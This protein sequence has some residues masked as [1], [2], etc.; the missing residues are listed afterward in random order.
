MHG[1]TTRRPGSNPARA[2]SDADPLLH[3]QR[4]APSC[5]DADG[6]RDLPVAACRNLA[7]KSAPPGPLRLGYL[8]GRVPGGQSPSSQHGVDQ[9]AC[10]QQDEADGEGGEHGGPCPPGP[11][12]CGS[13]SGEWPVSRPAMSTHVITGKAPPCTCGGAA[14]PARR[15]DPALSRGW[16]AAAHPALASGLFARVR[17]LEY[18]GNDQQFSTG[19]SG[20]DTGPGS[21]SGSGGGSGRG[22]GT[23]GARR[24]RPRAGQRPG[25]GRRWPG[26]AVAGRGPTVVRLVQAAPVPAVPASAERDSRVLHR[27]PLR[28]G[29]RALLASGHDSPPAAGY[30]ARR[31]MRPIEEAF[32]ERY[33]GRVSAE[34]GASR[35]ASP[36][37]PHPGRRSRR[38]LAMYLCRYAAAACSRRLCSYS[39]TP[40]ATSAPVLS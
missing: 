14:M 13:W 34:F 36:R 6:R 31:R 9:Q 15:D 5:A 12:L 37:P 16:R 33:P 2:V 17:V 20:G 29:G 1:K 8:P 32:A 11:A 38:E 18:E 28:A 35:S 24:F 26:G 10:A 39:L 30:P 21:G 19:G 4:S 25:W 7:L 27:R 22:R 23:G 40:P 3:P